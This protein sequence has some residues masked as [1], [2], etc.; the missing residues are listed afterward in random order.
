MMP[1]WLLIRW[2]RLVMRALDE[3]EL[4]LY[5]GEREIAECGGP[6]HVLTECRRRWSHTGRHVPADVR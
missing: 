4:C 2:D 3:D 5:P 6:G 1:G